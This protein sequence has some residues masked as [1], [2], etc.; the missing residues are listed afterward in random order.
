MKN[1]ASMY[2]RHDRYWQKNSDNDFSRKKKPKS[3]M[4][5]VQLCAKDFEK[6]DKTGAVH[7]LYNEP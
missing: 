6:W 2:S 3:I 4:L 7:T 5:N 1:Y